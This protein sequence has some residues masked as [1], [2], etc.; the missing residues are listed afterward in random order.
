LAIV[1]VDFDVTDQLHFSDTREE[2]SLQT[3]FKKPMIQL[4]G[5]FCIILSLHFA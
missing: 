3:A 1:C 4:G 2:K 5:K